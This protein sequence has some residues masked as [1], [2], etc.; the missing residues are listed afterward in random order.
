LSTVEDIELEE[1]EIAISKLTNGLPFRKAV[2]DVYY[3]NKML[4]L[5]KRLNASG[6][7]GIY[8]ITNI[9]NEKVY[10]GQSVDIGNRW[11]QHAK[12]GC[13]AEAPTG[14][15]L[16]PA[17]LEY[18]LSNFTFEILQIEPDKKKLNELEQYW[19]TFYGAK[20][21]GYSTK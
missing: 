20:S 9:L 21:F 8:K 3:K 4:D 16:Y 12:R 14:S 19:Q 15:K 17:L 10:V 13:G 18:G 5:V 2:Y 7:Q 11:K 6:V 1:L